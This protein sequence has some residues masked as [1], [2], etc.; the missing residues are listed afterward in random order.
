MG[1]DSV[2]FS[3]GGGRTGIV[4]S[5]TG[6]YDEWAA[7]RAPSLVRFA[8]GLVDGPAADAA[9]HRALAKLAARWHRV[10]TREDPD[11]AARAHVLAAIGGGQ[12]TRRRAAALLRVLEDRSDVEIADVLRCSE[13]A[14]RVHVQ[15]GLAAEPAG[16]D[17]Q[18]LTRPIVVPTSHPPPR[19][20]R[21]GAWAGALAVLALVGGI[22]W[23]DHVTSTPDGVITYP[24]VDV[25]SDW[26]VESY[27]G[28][29]VRVPVTWGFGGSPVRSDSFR[30]R[31]LGGCGAN[32]AA[33]LSSA[34][35]AT[36]ASSVTPFVGRPAVMTDRCVPWGSDGVLPRS[37][38]LWFA[39]PLAVGVEH[40]GSQVA[41]TRAV[42]DQKVSV[43]ARSSA[44]RRKILGTAEVVRV[45]GNGCPTRAVQQPIRGPAGLEPSSMSVCVYSEDTGA[46]E[47][48]WSGHTT[49][50]PARSY[51]DAVARAAPAGTCADLPHGRWLALGLHG[52]A[53]TRWDVVDLGCGAI[54]DAEGSV[55]LTRDTVHDWKLDGVEAYAQLPGEASTY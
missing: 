15:R 52:A 54:A 32:E 33:V 2:T 11:L 50:P 13:S 44:L 6:R 24:H 25:P 31:H 3:R 47:L 46:P 51:A 8:H 48:M 35:D 12:A 1:N 4:V 41:E 28:V 29:E 43:F 23:V 21:G 42:G 16:T 26:R 14:A 37:E 9:V 40:V 17:V 18:V 45:D 39:S 49:E 10:A 19:R 27:A 38:A 7:A 22:A 36:Y 30:G 55:P 34:D 5:V 53:G 20:R